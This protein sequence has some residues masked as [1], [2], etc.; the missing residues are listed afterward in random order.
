MI[1]S[2]A[3]AIFMVNLNNSIYG[4]MIMLKNEIRS[5]RQNINRATSIMFLVQLF[6]ALGAGFFFVVQNVLGIQ[7]ILGA[8]EPQN[9]NILWFI[10]FW[11]TDFFFVVMAVVLSYLIAGLPA[12]APAFALSI[13]FA[14]FAGAPIS[15]VETY[16]A[17][18]ATPLN[19]G[20][21]TNIGYMG[22]LIMAVFLA[23]CIK[24][25]FIAWHNCKEFLGG[26]LDNS[27]AKKRAAGKKIPETLTGVGIL[28]QVDLIVLVLI[29]PVVSAALT[30]LLI[31][32][33]IEIPFQALGEAMIAPLT[34]LADRS[35]VL[36]ALVMGLMV[37]F[38]LIGPVSMSAFAVSI[39]AF[40][41]G[42]AR[43]M[44]IY[45]ACF[46]TV[47][48][49]PLMNVLLQKITKKGGNCDADD[50]NFAVSGPINA[51][52]ENIK[53][54]VAFSM[55]YAY[56]SP[57]TVIPGLMLGS[58]AT[59]VLTALCG[60]VNTAYLTELP[61]YGNGET[62]SEMF[63][64]GEMYISFTLPLRSGDWLHCRLPLFFIILGGA[65]IGG[66]FMLLFK[67]LAYRSQKK[68]GTY[69]SCDGD[70]VL[71]FRHYAQKLWI[72]FKAQRGKLPENYMT[73]ETNNTQEPE[74]ADL[75][76]KDS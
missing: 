75:V 11:A 2:C 55:P 1:K 38:D 37:G 34:S 47:G 15:G 28:E 16:K 25:L 26:K 52:F 67:E 56:R 50:F 30:F 12:I 73:A 53:L 13:Y 24:Y 17:Y 69:V 65:L 40:A 46:V 64:R 59:G 14:H 29:M 76:K 6:G 35:V 20:G 71:E 49:V 23:Y 54:T 60:I 51:F 63:A 58:A 39:A 21:G 42:D 33:G 4:G 5:L 62:F 8:T 68:H 41:A 70:I 45:G 32:Y 66:L 43:L 48:W 22:Y 44:T 10:L 74:T 19:M 27:F 31:H 72:P 57:L 7:H 61:K 36:C 3:Y 18:F 9:E